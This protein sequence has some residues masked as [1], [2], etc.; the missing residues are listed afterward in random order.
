M[1]GAWMSVL[2]LGPALLLTPRSEA[3][4]F[5]VKSAQPFL[6]K[7]NLHVNVHLDLPLNARTEEA[8]SKGIPIDVVIEINMVKHRRWWRSAI[9]T[10]TVLRRR[11]Q[12]HALSRQYRV[13]G[14]NKHEPAE[15]FGSLSQALVHAGTLEAFIMPLTAKKEI[16]PDARYLLQLRARLDIEAL[17][18]LMR[19]L[20]YTMPSWRLS[21]GWTEWPIEYDHP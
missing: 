6:D 1:R 15:S 11:I 2:L 13:T 4:D 19:P 12:F 20:A 18:M 7:R 21:T 14:L 3:A 5:S 16:E 9:V 10:D 8:L 17:P